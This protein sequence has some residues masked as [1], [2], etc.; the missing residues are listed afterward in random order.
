MLS[1]TLS[2]AQSNS[3]SLSQT[4]PCAQ[5]NS[6]PVSVKL[7]PALS[8]TL[9]CAQSNSAGLSQTLPVSVKLCP[10]L[11]Q[12]LPQLSISAAQLVQYANSNCVRILKVA[13]IT[14]ILRKDFSWVSNTQL[15]SAGSSAL[16]SELPGYFPQRQHILSSP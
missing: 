6:L 5:S 1:Q 10:T 4:L 15:L 7:C 9:P 8:Q 14:K 2:Y 16:P 3:A 11:S 12:I 13:L